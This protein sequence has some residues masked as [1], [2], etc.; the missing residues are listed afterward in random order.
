MSRL[1]HFVKVKSERSASISESQVDTECSFDENASSKT[2]V[3]KLLR[4]YLR[5]C[6]E[7]QMKA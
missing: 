5:R 4:D 6:K 7:F 2:N 3:E 1:W